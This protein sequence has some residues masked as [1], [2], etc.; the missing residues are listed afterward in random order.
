[1]EIEIEEK[2]EVFSKN[3]DVNVDTFEKLVEIG[4]VDDIITEGG[5]N[6]FKLSDECMVVDIE[7]KD[8]SK[9]LSRETCDI[10]AKTFG[11]ETYCYTNGGVHLFMKSSCKDCFK[12]GELGEATFEFKKSDIFIKEKE[13]Y[14]IGKLVE[15]DKIFSRFSKTDSI[16]ST[17][18]L[19]G[20][21]LP[22][23]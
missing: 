15:N 13:Q 3:A 4:A 5:Y 12:N 16:V 19:S 1:M 17:A 9:A 14:V 8:K 10:Y 23:V 18:D 7:P 2:V 11:C 6:K 21:S 20:M 22:G